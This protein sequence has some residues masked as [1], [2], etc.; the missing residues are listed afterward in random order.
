MKLM[1]LNITIHYIDQVYKR[2]IVNLEESKVRQLAF[3][4]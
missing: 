3:P 1:K 4:H 2:I